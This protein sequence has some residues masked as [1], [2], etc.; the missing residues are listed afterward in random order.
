[1]LE[2]VRTFFQSV[3]ELILAKHNE[4]LYNS[5]CLVVLLILPI[6]LLLLV[7][8]LCCYGCCSGRHTPCKC[9]RRQKDTVR[10]KNPDDLWIQRQPQPIMMDSLS[11]PV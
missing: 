4:G 1:M 5:I 8:C 2:T 10:K 7:V 11:V 6:L 9:C 3:W